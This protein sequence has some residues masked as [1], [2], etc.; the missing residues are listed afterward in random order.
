MITSNLC[1]YLLLIFPI[2]SRCVPRQFLLHITYIN[3]EINILT[4]S[5]QNTFTLNFLKFAFVWLALLLRFRFVYSLNAE[6][7]Y[8][9]KLSV[10]SLQLL[11]ATGQ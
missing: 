9:D 10:I 6:T 1:W 3:K 8:P 11:E 7:S 5:K 2:T 4:F